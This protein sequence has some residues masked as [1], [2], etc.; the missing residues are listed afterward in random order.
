M[1]AKPSFFSS[2]PST[3][4]LFSNVKKKIGYPSME[5]IPKDIKKKIQYIIEKGLKCIETRHIYKVTPVISWDK[6]CINGKGVVVES[7][8]W[9]SLLNHMQPPFTLYCFALTL[10][11]ELDEMIKASPKKTLFEAFVMDAFGSVVAEYEADQ[12]THHL[13]TLPEAVTYEY[14]RRFSPGYCDWKLQPGQDKLFQLLKPNAI[15]LTCLPSGAM[16]PTKSI[17]AVMIGAGKIDKASPCFFCKE[18]S[19]AH[20]RVK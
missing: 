11:E 12:L 13:K 19:C 18:G 1:P 4:Y 20:R 5:T 15:G 3:D 2:I 14:S 7:V 17:T 10:G 16:V 9:A 8:K 6:S